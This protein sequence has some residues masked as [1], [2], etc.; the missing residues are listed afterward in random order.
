MAWVIAELL[1]TGLLHQDIM[2]VARGDL[3]DYGRMPKLENDAL[4]WD[5]QPTAPG[6]EAILRPVSNPF[7]ADGGM[8][9]LSGN[10]G[11]CIMKTSAVDPAR[12]TIEAPARVFSDQDAVIKA[13]KAGE[14]DKDVVVAVRFQGPRANGM[15][16]L[17]K[18]TP[19]L[20]VLQD[21]GFKV[22]LVTGRAHV[23]RQ[24]QSA[25][26]DPSF[27]RGIGWRSA[28]KAARWRHRPGMCR[29][30][31]AGRAGAP[32]GMGCARRCHGAATALRYR[33]RAFRA[34]PGEQR[35][36]RSGR[37]PHIRGD[38]R[39]AMSEIIA[40]DIGGTNAR[41]ARARLDESGVPVLG[42]V[43]KYRVADFPTLAA[44]WQRFAADEADSGGGALPPVA[45]IAFATAI[46]GEIIKLTNSSWVSIRP[47]SPPISA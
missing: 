25:C 21:K 32:G 1:R 20:G 29:Q 40:A 45:S 5:E 31:N 24:R 28:G 36:G 23:R 7:S 33:P 37:F 11:R 34:V 43:R 38:G 9:L 10:L 47:R 26:R 2:T 6:N 42:T 3:A 17:H 41:F 35:S 18:L 16:E 8:K 46:T 13:F 39:R 14:L 4:M 12:C 19:P 30:W 44:C 27:A 22:A 15:P